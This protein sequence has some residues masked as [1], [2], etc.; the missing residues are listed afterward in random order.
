MEDFLFNPKQCNFKLPFVLGTAFKNQF[1][2]IC[3]NPSPNQSLSQAFPAL[4]AGVVSHGR[5]SIGALSSRLVLQCKCN[6]LFA[7]QS[8]AMDIN[9][10]S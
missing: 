5:V 4:T 1:N 9:V 3:D 2:N 10:M 6:M 8:V 7:L